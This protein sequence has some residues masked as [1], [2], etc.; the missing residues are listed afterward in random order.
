VAVPEP[1]VIGQVRDKKT[2]KLLSTIHKNDKPSRILA[3]VN[4]RVDILEYELSHGRISEV[5]YG[6]G[7]LI[8]AIFE[9]TGLSGGSTWN[10]GSR[11]DAV[12][13]KELAVIRKV[14]DAKIIAAMVDEN[15]DL[16]GAIDAAIVRQVLG[17]NRSFAQVSQTLDL[18]SAALRDPD[19]T[20]WV[21]FG[22]GGKRAP[23]SAEAA[24]RR[25]AYIAARF[26]DALESLA[27][28]R[29]R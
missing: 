22:K 15:A 29:R 28:R 21:P 25:I 8:Q 16:L 19:A 6:E 1:P 27:Q 11:V 24:R 17:E 12:V 23:S 26:R 4:R 14:S 7:R 9:R 10:A 5:A 3:T 20:A 2:G 18:K 13:A